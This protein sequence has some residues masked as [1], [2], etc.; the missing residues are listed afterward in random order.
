MRGAAPHAHAVA[1]HAVADLVF[2]GADLVLH[3]ARIAGIVGG[4]AGDDPGAVGPVDRADRLRAARA[5]V[6]GG[7]MHGAVRIH[8]GG[9]GRGNLRR[10][11]AGNP[12]RPDPERRGRK[13]DNEL[14]CHKYAFPVAEALWEPRRVER[15]R[16]CWGSGVGLSRFELNRVALSLSLRCGKSC[17]LKYPFRAIG[18]AMRTL[19]RR[20]WLRLAA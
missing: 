17:G 6:G 13:A 7:G 1:P 2:V 16:G 3:R 18:C 19:M 5:G 15:A 10:R 12:E 11:P 4:G 20:L 8:V 14:R 9:A